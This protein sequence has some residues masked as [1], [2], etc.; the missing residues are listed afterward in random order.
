[1]RILVCNS[2]IWKWLGIFFWTGD[3]AW[4]LMKQSGGQEADCRLC[5]GNENVANAQT[6][7]V[8]KI[9]I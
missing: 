1:M 3:T 6:G 7:A 8:N 2:F 4:Q 9:G 5:F